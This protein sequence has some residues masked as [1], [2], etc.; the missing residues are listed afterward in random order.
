MRR[1]MGP[2]VAV[3][4]AGFVVQLASLHAL[5]SLG[6]VHYMLATALAVEAA[7][8]HNFAWHSRWTWRDRPRRAGAQA[9][10]RFVKFNGLSALSSIVGNVL[11]TGILVATIDMP[12]LVANAIAVA[13]VAAINFAGLDRWVFAPAPPGAARRVPTALEN[14]TTSNPNQMSQVFY[15]RA[16]RGQ[17]NTALARRSHDGSSACS[18]VRGVASLVLAALAL[19]LPLDASAAQLTAETRRAW[20]RYVATTEAR[21][22]RE[23]RTPGRFLSLDFDEPA[24]RKRARVELRTGGVVI[25]NMKGEDG[26]ELP[27]GT[28]HHWRGAVF[29]PGATVE[30]ILEAVADPTGARAHRQEDV[31]ETRVIA[32]SP[33]ALRLFLKLQRRVIVSVAYNTEHDVVYRTHGSGRASSRSVATRIAE[34]ANLG[35]PDEHERPPGVDRGFLWGLNSY[36]RYEAVPGGVVVELESLTLSRSVPWGVGA[37]VRPLVG[38]VARESLTRTLV[39]LRARFADHASAA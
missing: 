26:V 25:R 33:N 31:M 14:L 4:A 36:W 8:L 27:S 32:R 10:T 23:L 18:P 21:I 7:I 38:Q 3:G 34:V 28:L 24:E 5:V 30:E 39:A 35:D 6:G 37:V 1:R 15:A 19:A 20:Q 11:F 29:V 13:L 9:W 16:E 17:S 2:F 22:D 12:V